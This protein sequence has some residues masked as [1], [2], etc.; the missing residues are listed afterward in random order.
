MFN[1]PDTGEPMDHN[2]VEWKHEQEERETTG[3]INKRLLL[4]CL[5]K[6]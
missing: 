4:Y 6:K 5:S 2:H 1:L 3:E